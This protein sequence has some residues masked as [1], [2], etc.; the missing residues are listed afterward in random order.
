MTD[1]PHVIRY[2][3]TYVNKNGERTLMRPAQGRYTY[4]EFAEAQAWINAVMENTDESTLHQIWGNA[5]DFEV[6]SC[7]CYPGHYDPQTVWFD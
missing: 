1:R 5:P 2:V 6:R 4:S 3:P 7:P